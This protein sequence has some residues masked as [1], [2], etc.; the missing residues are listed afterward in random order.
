MADE[1]VNIP[2]HLSR[3]LL[4]PFT[5]VF[6]STALLTVFC[7][8]LMGM[9]AIWGPNPQPPLIASLF[10]TLK[11]GFTMGMFSVFGLLGVK[12]ITPPSQN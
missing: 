11:Y 9:I 1:I 7:G 5:M 6:L 3:F 10:E 2:F 8:S 4:C 12:N